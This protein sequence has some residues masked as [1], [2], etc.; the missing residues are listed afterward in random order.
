MTVRN[1]LG[2]TGSPDPIDP[3]YLNEAQVRSLIKSETAE[4]A[5]QINESGTWV[6]NGEDTGVE[7]KGPKGDPGELASF[8][9]EVTEL[10]DGKII[11]SGENA[12][13]VAIYTSSGNCYPIEKESIAKEGDGWA[14]SVDK[15]FAYDNVSS[16]TSPW[17]VYCAGGVKGERGR[18]GGTFP[19]ALVTALP[20]NPDPST[21]YLIPEV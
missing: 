14:I 10:T 18:D 3:D 17:Y 9:I 21:L 7:A 5:P 16:F 15:Y 19:I 13:P 20:E 4:Y 11:I 8:K 12:F 1:R 2:G 6:V